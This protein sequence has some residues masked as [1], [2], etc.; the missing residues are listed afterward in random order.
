MIF[1]CQN[2][3]GNVVYSPEK[4]SMY[5][6]HCE[7]IESQQKLAGASEETCANCGAPLSVPEFS[8][9][10]R[11]EH[12]GHYIVFDK[13]VEGE[14]EPNLI[15]PFKIGKEGAKEIL[16]REFKKRAFTPASFLSE[17]TLD[18]ME[19]TYVPF[20]LYD[21]LAHYNYV[22]EGTKV[23]SWRSGDKEYTETSYYRVVR[24]MDIDFDK[25]PVDASIAM[26]DGVMDLMEPY[27]YKA[28]EG[29]QDK[30]ISGFLSE[31]FNEDAEKLEPRAKRKAQND[32]EALLQEN[33]SGY[34]TLRAQQKQLNMDRLGFFYA[35]LP[36]WVYTYSYR[37]QK[38]PF[39]VNGQTGKVIG[40]TP[41]SGLKLAGYSA[42]A[43]AASFLIVNMLFM[44]CNLLA[45]F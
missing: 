31:Y 15:V 5:C 18:K 22:G 40:K 13:K 19:G 39:Y 29:F 28:L 23:R 38:F 41:M 30:Y 12:C 2:C 17:A 37:D 36:V 21:Y 44:I 6:P 27:D 20:W 8:S 26:D 16:K 35:L 33:L 45:C 11:C 32:A 1:K 24:E 43:F 4:G 14:Y 7:G 10:T 34:S 9:S 25:I 3:G 42:T